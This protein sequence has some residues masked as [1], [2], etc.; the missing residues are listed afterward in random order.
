MQHSLKGGHVSAAPFTC[1]PPSF[2]GPRRS[3]AIETKAAF[4]PFLPSHISVSLNDTISQGGL[5]SLQFSASTQLTQLSGP[6][7][8]PDPGGSL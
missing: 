7:D 2:F 5:N 4:L 6:D 3:F 1:T 8:H